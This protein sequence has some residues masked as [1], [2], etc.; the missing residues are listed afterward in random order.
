MY[1]FDSWRRVNQAGRAISRDIG[2]RRILCVATAVTILSPIARPES[3][4]AVAR[5]WK[6]RL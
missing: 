5:H 2:L 4:E 1:F 3:T 6:I